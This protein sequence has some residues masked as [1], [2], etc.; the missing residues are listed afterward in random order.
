LS[1]F[2]EGSAIDLQAAIAEMIRVL[3]AIE[4]EYGDSVLY[5]SGNA[6]NTCLILQSLLTV[7]Y[8]IKIESPLVSV[9]SD[10]VPLFPS[11]EFSREN[12]M[13]EFPK[14]YLP[15]HMPYPD[16]LKLNNPYDYLLIFLKAEVD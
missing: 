6:K 7:S 14:T 3:S 16:P 4:I 13:S 2:T 11:L 9:A 1:G 5:G 10:N 8:L 15:E 12:H